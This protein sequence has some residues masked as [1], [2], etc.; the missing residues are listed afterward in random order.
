MSNV[1][2][3]KSSN[4]VEKDSFDNPGNKSKNYISGSQYLGASFK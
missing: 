1:V 2:P 4:G 3:I